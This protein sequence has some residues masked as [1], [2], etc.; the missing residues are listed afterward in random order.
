MN[1]ATIVALFG[2][3]TAGI[4]EAGNVLATNF[5]EATG[6]QRPLSTS[7]GVGISTGGVVQL[8]S[9]TSADPSGLIAGLTSPAGLAALL[10][11]FIN[12]GSTN[13]IGT[14]FAGLYASDKSSPILGSSPLVGKSIYTLIGNAASLAASTELAIIRDDQ[15]FAADAPVFAGLADISAGTSVVLFGNPNGPGFT[16][17]LGAAN[18]S[19]SLAPVPEPMSAVLLLT[20][21]ALAGRR[22]R[23]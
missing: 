2:L 10:A 13:A 1:K 6:A 11:D 22:R 12:F 7:A 3:L 19:L 23:A 17:A 15:S 4:S 21:L 5:D 18:S 9:F 8:G 14:D 16:T 20:G